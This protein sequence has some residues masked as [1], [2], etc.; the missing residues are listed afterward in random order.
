M[1]LVVEP[2]SW[3]GTNM[4]TYSLQSPPGS[5]IRHILADLCASATHLQKGGLKLEIPATQK[6]V[7]EDFLSAG[8]RDLPW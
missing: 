4:Y 5:L 6:A 3:P 7:Q 8:V 2:G 1:S